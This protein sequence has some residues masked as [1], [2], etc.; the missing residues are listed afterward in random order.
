MFIKLGK[1]NEKN[2]LGAVLFWI[3]VVFCA[4]AVCLVS[5]D[6]SWGDE[7]PYLNIGTKMKAPSD[8]MVDAVLKRQTG[9]GV[10]DQ[11]TDPLFN[12]LNN[13][14]YQHSLD[15]PL[16]KF[17]LG[18]LELN[19][20]GIAAVFQAENANR[21]KGNV[22]NSN[23]PISSGGSSAGLI[24]Y[25]LSAVDTINAN[26]GK[27]F[28][29]L[30][31]PLGAILLMIAFMCQVAM[32]GY[33][34]LMHD[35][36]FSAVPLQAVVF[37]LIIFL[38]AIGFFRT[39]VSGLITF[40]NYMSNTILPMGTQTHLM[41]SI[42]AA[43]ATIGD[44]SVSIGSLVGT[45]FRILAYV[46]VK[47]LL[48]MRDVLM[49]LTIVTGPTCIA[50]GYFSTYGSQ[51]PMR[52]YLSGWIKS[53]TSLLLWGPFA[54]LVL[55]AMGIVSIL[56]TAGEVS[57][58]ASGI[59]GLAALFAAKDIPKMSDEFGNIALASLIG[60]I[61]P[62]VSKI[63]VGGAGSAMVVGGSLAFRGART[64]G[65]KLRE[66]S[67]GYTTA[68][69]IAGT[70]GGVAPILAG[71]TGGK[72]GEG[73]KGSSRGGQTGGTAAARHPEA[74]FDIAP[75]FGRG[76]TAGK[77]KKAGEN[78]PWYDVAAGGIGKAARKGFAD[79]EQ[80]LEEEEQKGKK[81]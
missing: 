65:R 61:A 54:A 37:R 3:A 51:E 31:G 4:A 20:A 12:G 52:E 78:K 71:V 1:K 23:N 24:T 69:P 16:T 27:A 40:S 36:G 14:F 13:T 49:S 41:G 15:M 59:F 21:S 75:I 81:V 77:E 60:M 62:A 35:R 80:V 57:S 17:V 39:Y 74:P 58:V 33:N 72:D 66:V 34:G 70:H 43:S 10:I 63:S 5:A 56:T 22:S 45:F 29:F 76:A 32:I 6:T 26:A 7:N 55:N 38:L 9:V 19:G 8:Q 2:R 67:D 68:D 25:D 73:E 48:V 11:K 28:R 46:C 53:F 42:T 30:T 64:A 79:A 44:G 18:N 50:L 47:I